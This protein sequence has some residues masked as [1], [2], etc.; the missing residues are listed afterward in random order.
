M[1]GA[2][3]FILQEAG[4]SFPVETLIDHGCWDG[5]YAEMLRPYTKSLI[6]LDI[7]DTDSIPGYDRYIRAPVEPG[8]SYLDPL[9]DNS[10]DLVLIIASVGMNAAGRDDGAPHCG[11][12]I[13]Y[14]GKTT[15]RQGRY[16]T[17][18]NYPRVV[19]PGGHIVIQEWEAYPERRVGK[20]GMAAVAQRIDEFYPHSEL[21]GFTMVAKGISPNR[22]G[23]YIV[24]RKAK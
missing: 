3:D 12:W 19:K 10:V 7:L 1:R 5:H 4:V 21:A 24:Y 15:E 14:F 20:I 16:F 11:D 17:P 8:L 22:I 23:P 6:G 2:V 13:D 18:N 9:P